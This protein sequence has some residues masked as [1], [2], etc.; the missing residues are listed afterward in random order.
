MAQKSYSRINITEREII[1]KGLAEKK[2]QAC[3]AEELGYTPSVISRE[4]RRDG[5]NRN[6]YSPSKAQ[7]HADN[8]T[9][10]RRKKYKLKEN[11]IL[12]TFVIKKISKKWSPEQICGFLE[13]IFCENSPFRLSHETIYRYV[14]S[15]EDK[16]LRNK[17]IA[18]L[19][20]RRRLRRSRKNNNPRRSKIKDLVSIHERPKEVN[21]RLVPGH[22][23]G[24]LIIGKNHKSAIGTLVERTT[25]KTIIV[26]FDNLPNTKETILGFAAAL[27]LLPSHM[28]KS[29]TYDRGSEMS[30]HK[31]FTEMTGIPVFFAD[32]YSPW[33]RGTNENTNG[34]IR[35][36]FP[37]KTD[38]REYGHIDFLKVQKELN[39]RPRKIL[40]FDSPDNWFSHFVS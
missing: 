2:T 22:W 4:I 1:Y 8:E 39:S 30:G 13:K 17:L 14:Y 38:F 35:Q 3:I 36:Y 33:Q 9:L 34:L 18:C 29:L 26:P 11:T 15:L 21:D 23:E 28:K 12:E 10:K 31:K 7:K 40:N 5:M 27:A 20:Q 25:R 37:K 32:P 16:N 19:R 24:D 6:T